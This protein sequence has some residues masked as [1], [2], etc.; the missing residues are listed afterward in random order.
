MMFEDIVNRYLFIFL[1]SLLFG[2]LTVSQ[3]TSTESGMLIV[4][5]NTF[6]KSKD[7]KLSSIYPDLLKWTVENQNK[8]KLPKINVERPQDTIFT[9]SGSKIIIPFSDNMDTTLRQISFIISRI[10][11]NRNKGKEFFTITQKHFKWIDAKTLQ[12]ETPVNYDA[13]SII[14]NWWGCGYPLI[15]ENGIFLSPYSFMNFKRQP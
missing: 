15:G 5:L 14:F 1:L 11:N 2:R 6:Y 9:M 4:F 7:K 13:F 8:N 10:E 12:M 3:T